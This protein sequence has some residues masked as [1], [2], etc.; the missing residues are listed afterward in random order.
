[1][2]TLWTPDRLA[3]LQALADEGGTAAELALALGLTVHQ[4]RHAVR[5]HG[6]RLARHRAPCALPGVEEAA[7]LHAR[8]QR[9]LPGLKARLL[10][11]LEH[12]RS[13][14]PKDD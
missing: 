10:R 1:M 9:R 14:E 6:V 4:V 3:A 8:W 2:S 12:Y 7:A 5:H 11:D 13:G